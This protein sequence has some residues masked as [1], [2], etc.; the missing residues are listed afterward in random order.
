MAVL[1]RGVGFDVIEATDLTL[2]QMRERL[3]AFAKKANGADMALLYYA[4]QGVAVNGENYL[5]AVD[6]AIKA[7]A[8]IARN[9]INLGA[10]VDAMAKAETRLVFYDAS[11]D[12]PYASKRKISRKS[13]RTVNPP[14]MREGEVR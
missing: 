5:L 12:N 9:A 7:E 2:S 4:G 11:R 14:V 10:A 3:A 1:L 13:I 8:D 6:A